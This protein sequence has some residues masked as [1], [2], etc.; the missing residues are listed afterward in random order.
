MY[1]DVRNGKLGDKQFDLCEFPFNR[2]QKPLCRHLNVIHKNACIF[3]SMI[4]ASAGHSK[5]IRY[6]VQFWILLMLGFTLIQFV[7]DGN[8]QAFNTILLQNLRRLP[9]MMLTAYLFNDILLPHW[10]TAKKYLIFGLLVILL[11]YTA[12][13][14]DRMINVY[15]YEP[16]F[17]EGTFRQ[18]PLFE[19][20]SDVSFLFE[21]Y[22]PALL[23]ATLIM[24]LD[25]LVNR[26]N[27]VERQ[28]IQL[29]RDKK[30]AELNVL[31]A[32]IHPHFLF[33]TLNNLYALTV[34][35]SDKA[36]ETVAT[37]STML[38][39]MLYQ[40]NDR[41][42][43]LEKEVQL[44]ENYM[45]LEQ[46][47]YGDTLD[48][49]FA[50]CYPEPVEGAYTQDAKIAP[51]ILLSIVE[52]AYKH[53]VSAATEHPKIQIDLKQEEDIMWFTVKNTIPPQ[54]QQDSTGYT[55]GIGVQNIKQQL[56]LLYRDFSY[57]V[58]ITNGWYCVALRI[59]LS[60][61]IH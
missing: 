15:V 21:G 51:L 23:T 1:S 10:Y 37:L 43:P 12:G 39:Y 45:A 17:R 27:I 36:P 61:V 24:T 13:V 33:N 58:D 18:E 32:Q 41:L 31:K 42:V 4:K 22:I 25:R 26:K 57:T 44:L 8:S 7:K 40:C 54:K 35:K 19:I 60:D 59:N 49:A 47:R 48:V 20:L 53:G 50:K 52:N 56:G 11:F 2:R 3:G 38:D 34:K 16:L 5:N 29:E 6:Q 28:N 55:K 30:I 46:L 14:L 9:A